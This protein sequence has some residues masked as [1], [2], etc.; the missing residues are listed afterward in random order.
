MIMLCQSSDSSYSYF[1]LFFIFLFTTIVIPFFIFTSLHPIV[2]INDDQAK[3][4]SDPVG[5]G[6]PH[7]G[8]T[9]VSIA[10]ALT[11]NQSEPSQKAH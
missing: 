4:H 6:K 10:T 1:G 9:A 2:T 11:S 3:L 7:I 5:I 8:S